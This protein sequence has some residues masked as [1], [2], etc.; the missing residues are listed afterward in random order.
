[1]G[2]RD[3]AL[4]AEKLS[5]PVFGKYPMSIP[6]KIV[7]EFLVGLKWDNSVPQPPIHWG[8]NLEPGAT[9]VGDYVKRVVDLTEFCQSAAQ[10][11]EMKAKPNVNL[12]L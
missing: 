2:I 6:K 8:R 12:E 4:V 3:L 9:L 7:T 10:N 11:R 5:E 1:M